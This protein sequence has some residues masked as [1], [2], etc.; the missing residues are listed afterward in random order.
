MEYEDSLKAYR[1]WYSIMKTAKDKSRA[2]GLAEGRAEGIRTT[3]ANMKKKG[4]DND[5]IAEMT[6]LPIEEIERLL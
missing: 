5:F 2:E 6:G 4:L 1:D 3:A